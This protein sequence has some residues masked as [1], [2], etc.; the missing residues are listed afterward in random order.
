MP[1][2]GEPV[3]LKVGELTNREEFGR[4][5][6]RL[7]T[8]TMA[9]L[10]VKEGDVI[11]IQG[12]DLTGAL[13]VR[14]YPA[15]IGLN[16]IRM[17]GITRRN[18]GIGVGETIKVSKAEPKDASRV[19]L[20]PAQKGIM[21]QMSPE[22]LK[23]NLFMRP[24]TKR[25]IIMPFP[26]VKQRTNSPFDDFFGM[27]IEDIF[28]TPI[29]GETKLAV[30]STN[31]EGITRI[32]EG[33]EVEL[34]PEA[35]DILEDTRIPTI[36]YEDIGG[37]HEEI[38]KIREMVE[39]PLRHPE[40]FTRL[41]IE[42]PKGVLLYGTP[43]SGKTLLAK[44]VANESG[45]NFTAINGP[46]IMCVAGNTPILAN[47]KLMS[48]EDIYKSAKK[49]ARD[50]VNEGDRETIVFDGIKTLSMNPEMRIEKDM[51]TEVTKLEA[52]SLEV[53]TEDGTRIAV[54]SNQPFATLDSKCK[55][56]WKRA[57]ELR[58][59]DYIISVQKINTEVMSSVDWIAKLDPES[60]YIKLDNSLSAKAGK[61]L[62]RLDEALSLF[63]KKK[64]E[65]HTKTIAFAPTR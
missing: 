21:L 33:T 36:T 9:K 19:T 41:G 18:A 23:K 62:M 56:Q 54:S 32:T 65:K 28:F 27:N 40:L 34:K 53:M 50:I 2:R 45:A 49:K 51:I 63:D 7:D 15:D 58:E 6:V 42:P 29:P 59:G 52:D 16:I 14:A 11:A 10:G 57:S 8:K 48:A 43:G 60:V 5:I 44:A 55:I 37:L 13:A 4:G 20:A 64:I 26:V 38:N 24:V 35:V 12:K 46:E 47:N 3:T 61:S 22:L 39:L 1:E 30:V 17:D 25:D 31:P